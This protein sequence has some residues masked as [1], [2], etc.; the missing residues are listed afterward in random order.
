MNYIGTLNLGTSSLNFHEKNRR[1]YKFYFGKN[2]PEFEN[3]DIHSNFASIAMEYTKAITDLGWNPNVNLE[4]GLKEL[5][6][7]YLNE[8][9]EDG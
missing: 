3:I 7:R 5:I 8:M 2:N 6:N 4:T 9:R 1:N